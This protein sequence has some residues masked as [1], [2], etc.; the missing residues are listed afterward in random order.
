MCV[1]G[2]V[3]KGGASVLSDPICEEHTEGQSRTERSMRRWWRGQVGSKGSEGLGV[4]NPKVGSG[5]HS[6][7]MSW[8]TQLADIH[9]LFLSEPQYPVSHYLCF[10]FLLK[11]EFLKDMFIFLCISRDQKTNCMIMY[12]K[13]SMDS[14][15]GANVEKNWFAKKNPQDPCFSVQAYEP[16]RQKVRTHPLSLLPPPELSWSLLQKSLLPAWTAEH[17]TEHFLIYCVIHPEKLHPCTVGE[18]VENL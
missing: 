10:W 4:P 2:C 14:S 1:C 3:C 18:E 8:D 9:T 13:G 6:V 11:C 5:S 16:G 15:M 7:E 17:R 12:S